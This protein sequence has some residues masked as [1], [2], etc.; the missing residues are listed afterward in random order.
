MAAAKR[1]SRKKATEK[2][3]VEKKV[4]PIVIEEVK[5][6]DIPANAEIIESVEVEEEIVIAEEVISEV[7]KV[8]EKVNVEADKVK[9]YPAKSVNV[10]RLQA[11]LVGYEFLYVNK[12]K[13]HNIYAV[14][15]GWKPSE[16]DD[17][18]E[19]MKN[20]FYKG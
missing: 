19:L 12:A 5:I 14:G 13:V 18:F 2:K 4:D 8:D 7:D 1:G 16:D 6:E 3:E 11:E 15:L 10:K 9:T 17:N 20:P